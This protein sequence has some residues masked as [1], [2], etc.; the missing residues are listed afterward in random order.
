MNQEKNFVNIENE[1]DLWRW[2]TTYLNDIG[3]P[4]S[5]F[6]LILEK[7]K[8]TDVT[9][10][11]N[12][13]KKIFMPKKMILPDTE[14]T[15][16]NTNSKIKEVPKVPKG[17]E[18]SKVPK[19][20][21]KKS[22]KGGGLFSQTDYTSSIYCTYRLHSYNDLLSYFNN[23]NIQISTLTKY[24]L[25]KMYLYHY[26]LDYIKGLN[27]ILFKI[28]NHDLPLELKHIISDVFTQISIEIYNIITN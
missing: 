25:K 2:Y 23:N 18:V 11:I 17:K 1:H 8:E 10:V 7:L 14:N 26:N 5:G 9:Q 15:N 13:I 16:V 21:G 12:N 20:K 3:T 4:P 22:Q 27:Y 28:K 24:I 6:G 19:G